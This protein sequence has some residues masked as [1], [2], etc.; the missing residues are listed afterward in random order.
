[1]FLFLVFL[2]SSY[3]LRPMPSGSRAED[4]DGTKI[5]S[6]MDTMNKSTQLSF[7]AWLA[8]YCFSDA[9][10]TTADA[11]TDSSTTVLKSA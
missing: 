2:D 9:V 4:P 3:L 10:V 8:L 7:F 1:M 11:K 5:G 6:P